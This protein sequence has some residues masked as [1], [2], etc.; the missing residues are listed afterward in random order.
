MEVLKVITSLQL[1]LCLFLGDGWVEKEVVVTS[2]GN[3]E[4]FINAD[5]TAFIC[6][7]SG[8]RQRNGDYLKI[9][10]NGKYPF[11]VR[12]APSSAYINPKK[13][14]VK[15]ATVSNVFFDMG[16]VSPATSRVFAVVEGRSSSEEYLP[17]H[18]EVIVKYYGRTDKAAVSGANS[19]PGQRSS[20]WQGSDLPGQESTS[21]RA[22]ADIS[23]FDYADYS[24]Y[25]FASGSSY[26]FLNFSCPGQKIYYV[27][28]VFSYDP[29]KPDET[30]DNLLRAY[31]RYVNKASGK[32]YKFDEVIPSYT[33][34]C[35]LYFEKGI[36]SLTKEEAAEI[37]DGVIKPLERQRIQINSI[38][39]KF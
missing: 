21:N 9:I 7:A 13:A 34:P 33:N 17:T 38:K 36:R 25:K 16:Q 32:A 15:S 31:L 14:T 37:R 2:F 4:L 6:N 5:V 28:E 11:Y 1:L 19:G 18:A 35:S 22:N 12:A 10:N 30:R 26:G 3:D 23:P 27:T 20:D 39:V 24:D 8:N 29:T